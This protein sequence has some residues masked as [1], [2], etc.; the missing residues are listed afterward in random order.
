MYYQNSVF[1]QML[2]L[3]A[4]CNDTLLTHPIKKKSYHVGFCITKS[5]DITTKQNMQ[6]TDTSY[7]VLCY[8]V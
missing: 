5:V 1:D 6:T 7:L 8:G 3:N 2:R 4:L